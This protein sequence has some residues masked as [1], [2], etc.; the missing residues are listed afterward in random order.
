MTFVEN[1]QGRP[2]LKDIL[3]SGGVESPIG[4]NGEKTFLHPRFSDSVTVFEAGQEE[5]M[6]AVKLNP[7]QFCQNRLMLGARRNSSC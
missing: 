2:Q 1:G 4:G 5:E 6:V 7:L 3:G